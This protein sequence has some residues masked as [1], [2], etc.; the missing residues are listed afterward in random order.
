MLNHYDSNERR[1]I[2]CVTGINK[3]VLCAV[4]ENYAKIAVSL[5]I[6]ENFFG[7]WIE[8]RFRGIPLEPS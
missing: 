4:H 2:V 1:D 8:K 7:T 5:K 3:A 6:L